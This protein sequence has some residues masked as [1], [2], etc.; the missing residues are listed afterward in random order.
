M[1]EIPTLTKGD[2]VAAAEALP[3]WQSADG[4]RYGSSAIFLDEGRERGIAVVERFSTDWYATFYTSHFDYGRELTAQSNPYYDDGIYS[5]MAQMG[6][7]EP[8]SYKIA[9]EDPASTFRTIE[10]DRDAEQL[11]HEDVREFRDRLEEALR[12]C[13]AAPGEPYE[14]TASFDAPTSGYVQW[15][16]MAEAGTPLHIE[17]S[18]GAVYANPLNPRLA[19]MLADLGWEAPDTDFRNA[20]TR[21]LDPDEIDRATRL[22][23]L[24]LLAVLGVER[25]EL[26]RLLT[27]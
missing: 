13:L 21:A 11:D 10:R 8:T 7:P 2:I 5:A 20:W 17:V 4:T 6:V 1:T 22:V 12:A 18:D 23:A 27:D 16:R 24:A 15:T 3:R 19:R 9:P 14:A 25:G 26:R